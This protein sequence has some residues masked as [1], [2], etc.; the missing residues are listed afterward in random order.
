M[1]VSTYIGRVGS[2]AV[3]LGIG[4]AATGGLG[5]A[6]AAPEDS[7]GSSPN[8]GV[9][10]DNPSSVGPASRNNTPNNASRTAS[11]P[12]EHGQVPNGSVADRS[13]LRIADRLPDTG[14]SSRHKSPA[15]SSAQSLDTVSAS[16]TLS[17]STGPTGDRVAVAES[18]AVT[19]AP[20]VSVQPSVKAPISAHL[21][22]QSAVMPVM[23]PAA[24]TTVDAQSAVGTVESV[25]S[26]LFGVNPAA[27]VESP[28][29]WVMLAAA[30]RQIG[31][32]RP[33]AT[34]TASTGQSVPTA[35][36]TAAAVTNSPPV[37]SAVV[38]GSPNAST[39][40]VIGTVTASD[41]NGDK[42]TYKATTS[43]NGT[44]SITTAGV[45]TYTPTA[46]A[47]HAAAKVGA[48]TSTTTDTV[49]VTVT[50]S[51]G[52]TATSTVTV[53]ISPFNTVPTAKQTVGTPNAT[54]GVVTG[55]VTGTDADQD[56]LTYSGSTTT[57]KGAVTV[58]ASTGA[59]T[60][61]PTAT[62]RHAAAKIGATTA[63]TTDTFTVTVSD[64][65]GGTV[66]VPV[67][68]TISPK[69]TAPVSG[70]STIG[71]PDATTGAITGS[72]K[73]TDAEA[74]P[75]TYSAPATTTKGSVSLNA[76]T[77]AFTYTPTAI[78]RNTAAGSS[79]T[80]ADKTDSFTVTVTDGYGGSTSIPVSVAVSPKAA[81]PVAG[82]VTFAFNYGTGSQ[83][84][85]P[86][87]KAAL[88]TA[89]NAVAANIA[90]PFP[91]TIVYDVTA[92]NTTSRTLATAS[93]DLAS[94]N[95]GF[96]ETVV[97][98]KIQ[99]GVDANGTAADGTITVN[100]G[101]PWSFSNTVSNSQYD[102]I[103]TAMHE[104][105]H[106]FG[107]ISFIS[108]A[109]ANTRTTWTKFDSFIMT[110]SKV[111]VINASTYKFNTTYNSNLTGANGGLYFGGPNAIAA[112]G[113]LVPLYTPSTWAAGSSINHLNDAV[114]TGVNRK[115]MD[116]IV[117]TGLGVRALSGVEL[118][119]LKDLGYTV[120]PVQAG[121]TL[122]FVI[123]AFLRRRRDLC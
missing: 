95:A 118:G 74:D 73:A 52:A 39:G 54:T 56:V 121:A 107:F 13:A 32:V 120:I 2:L 40:A 41:P 8:T 49:T 24:A 98:D 30:R 35:A 33:T 1:R 64:G 85:T 119:I 10:G 9:A 12:A 53:P 123:V 66:A 91:V 36:A 16:A 114:F 62:A 72:V 94:G 69:N 59:F 104:I 11:A 71:T 116:A 90:A 55:T 43:T 81:T 97:E 92:T 28:V 42:I 117:N 23:T 22:A 112:Y 19:A 68:V 26:P 6:W 44:V 4:A 77:G 102:F 105:V 109:G 45:F 14:W 20:S 5:V 82:N 51:K 110:S 113:G 29:S 60:Y 76:S 50:D 70:T 111:N 84:W 7:P 15:P 67:T 100:F 88:Q 65:Y 27:P 18:V 89:A 93:S 108:N 17:S 115:L 47:R 122:L 3:A 79:A 83:Y 96:S 31:T 58:T 25:L 86:N 57:A 21:V 75:L 38:L 103:S 101:M 87:A 99:T 106:S 63:D 78:A 34:A 37:I 46:A 80:V 61:T 48:T